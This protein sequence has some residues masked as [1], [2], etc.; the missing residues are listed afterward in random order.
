MNLETTRVRLED[1]SQI[2]Y[3]IH[4]GKS[5]AVEYRRVMILKFI[6]SYGFGSG[7]NS[8]ATYMRA[9]GEAA[10]EAWDPDALILD[11]SDLDYEWGDMMDYVFDMGVDKYADLPFPKAMVVSERCEEAIRT[12]LLGLYSPKGIEETGWVFRSLEDAW[13]YVEK[14]LVEYKSK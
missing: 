5:A 12:L 4:I 9:M 1:L 6:G 13:S 8:D 14:K 3:E 10:L 7:G 2:D 11:L